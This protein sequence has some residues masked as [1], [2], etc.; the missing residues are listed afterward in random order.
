VIT[1]PVFSILKVAENGFS[2]CENPDID[3]LGVGK[4]FGKLD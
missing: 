3:P 4:L 1:S 2:K